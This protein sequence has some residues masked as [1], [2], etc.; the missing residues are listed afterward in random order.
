MAFQLANISDIFEWSLTGDGADMMCGLGSCFRLGYWAMNIMFV[1]F[2]DALVEPTMIQYGIPAI[3]VS[4]VMMFLRN[5]LEETDNKRPQANIYI[6]RTVSI[7]MI[8][9]NYFLLE[10]M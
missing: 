3:F 5:F 9:T 8:K 1:L 4:Q 2:A 6:H 10:K 7:L